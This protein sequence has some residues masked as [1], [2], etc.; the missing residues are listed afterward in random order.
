MRIRLSNNAIYA[1]TLCVVKVIL[2]I[3]SLSFFIH[4]YESRIA[5]AEGTITNIG[6]TP[7]S[8]AGMDAVSWPNANPLMVD[9]YGHYI[10]FAESTGGGYYFTYSNDKGATWHSINT[11][12]AL[13]RPTSVYD[14]I[15]DKIHILAEDSTYVNYR[16]YIIKRD[17][18]YN[19]T[20]FVLDP[21][22]ST[23][24]NF[25]NSA[26]C[27]TTGGTYPMLFFKDDG[28]NGIL[29]AFWEVSKTCSGTTRF[30]N[31]ASM[32]TLSN[33]VNDGVAANWAP[34]NGVDD[35]GSVPGPSLV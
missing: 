12:G 26:V 1:Y 16:R 28:L 24:L 20:D 8:D 21:A 17:S 32:R 2:I 34:L 11:N 23:P 4:T 9:S 31:R 7:G 10:A 14:S 15:H 33:D 25:E 13:F 30:E 18:S 35:S 6:V 27:T 3:I 19:I 22:I 29:V 5:L